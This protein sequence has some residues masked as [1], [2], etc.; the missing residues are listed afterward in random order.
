MTLPRTH[1]EQSAKTSTSNNQKPTESVLLSL[2]L[3]LLCE[4]GVYMKIKAVRFVKSEGSFQFPV[5]A[6]GMFQPMQVYIILLLLLL[7]IIYI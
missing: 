6:V 5:I 3:V 4:H 2:T 1:K 7:Y